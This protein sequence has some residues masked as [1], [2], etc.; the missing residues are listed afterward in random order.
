VPSWDDGVPQLG[1]TSFPAPPSGGNAALAAFALLAT[2]YNSM[3]IYML[4]HAFHA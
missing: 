4:I 3:L 2:D 1:K